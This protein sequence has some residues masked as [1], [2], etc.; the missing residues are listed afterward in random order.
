M[1]LALGIDIGT[2][3]VRTAVLDKSGALIAMARASHPA[4]TGDAIDAN[5]WW[6]AVEECLLAQVQALHEDGIDPA[7]ISTIAV[8]G[9]SGSM[10]LTDASIAP[11]SPALMYNSKGFEAEANEI[12]K[13]AQD[14]HITQ[15]SNSALAR[16]MRLCRL[17]TAT[18]AHLM[19]QA[20]FI[21]ARL[22]R[23]GGLSDHNN[24]LKTG[25]D[26]EDL[27]WP[28]W[29]GK[30]IEPALLP[31]VFPVGTPFGHIN[32]DVANGLDLS[33]SIMVIAGTTD[34][35]AAFVA[36]A[37]IAPGVAVTSLGS[38]LA[39]KALSPKRIDDPDIGLYSHRI[40]DHWLVGGA[41]N[42]GGSVLAHFFSPEELAQL[43]SEIDPDRPTG[44]D[45]YP[46]LTPGERF[47]IND[48]D[49]AGN[50]DPRPEA[51][52]EFLA[53]LF[54]GIARVEL[55]CYREI[56]MRGGAFPTKIF[57]AGGGAQNPVFTAIRA[58]ALGVE[59]AIATQSEAAVGAAR[60]ALQGMGQPL[61][62]A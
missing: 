36:S 8:D 51:D 45:Y 17:V 29:I 52:H 30:V 41:S 39:I 10:V 11:V 9:T 26:P 14:P 57:S 55:R 3:G 4:Q 27:A 34:S 47:P 42:T 50:L 20:D 16:A 1:T 60:I 2:S 15:G 37:P 18:P 6:Q 44:L 13:W 54:D 46:L 62:S 19:H 58:K 23:R 32:P 5:L 38:T 61:A 24:A 35:V 7:A 21:A 12:R 31:E 53:G 25:F 59:I 48:P 43:S 28:E 22:M 33:P 49:F 56:E 40:G